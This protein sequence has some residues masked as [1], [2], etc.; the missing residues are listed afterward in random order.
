MPG[1]LTDYFK[2]ADTGL[3]ALSLRAV[4]SARAPTAPASPRTSCHELHLPPPP[5]ADSLPVPSARLLGSTR[6]APEVSVTGSP[7]STSPTPTAT[8]ADQDSTLSSP[9]FN[10]GLPAAH[11]A[12]PLSNPDLHPCDGLPSERVSDELG[13]DSSV[14]DTE[15][16]SGWTTDKEC[17]TDDDSDVEALDFVGGTGPRQFIRPNGPDGCILS[18]NVPDGLHFYGLDSD[19]DP[20]FRRLELCVADFSTQCNLHPRDDLSLIREVVDPPFPIWP[21]L[22]DFLSDRLHFFSAAVKDPFARGKFSVDSRSRR[23]RTLG[24]WVSP[25]DFV[26][27]FATIDRGGVPPALLSQFRP[28]DCSEDDLEPKYSEVEYSY[29]PYDKE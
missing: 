4:S 8:Y 3:G 26:D 7:L 6:P 25:D 11:Q 27:P 5:T 2:P 29:D 10:A 20:I 22:G 14:V 1:L 15:D 28:G 12:I 21:D 18:V 16:E 13:D 24:C 19:G 17:V 9:L 23:T